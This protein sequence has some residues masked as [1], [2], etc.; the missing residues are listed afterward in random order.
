MESRDQAATL[1]KDELGRTRVRSAVLEFLT[2]Q[3][4]DGLVTPEGKTALK[5]SIAERASEAL[6]HTKV[7]DV[8]FAEFVVQF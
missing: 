6:G 7:I 3:T 5:Q 2:L 1:A 4:A 8:L